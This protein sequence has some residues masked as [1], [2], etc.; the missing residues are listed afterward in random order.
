MGCG[1]SKEAY[2]EGYA[3]AAAQQQQGKQPQMQYAPPPQAQQKPGRGRKS[4]AATNL[5]FLSI[6]AN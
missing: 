6:L 1:N 3:A 2:E 4:K 5:G